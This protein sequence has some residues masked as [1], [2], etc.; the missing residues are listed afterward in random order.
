MKIFALE[1]IIR[2][3]Y[4]LLKAAAREP[5]RPRPEKKPELPRIDREKSWRLYRATAHE[6]LRDLLPVVR[7]D[8][9]A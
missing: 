4:D 5:L 1:R 8:Q 9:P 3:H 2:E 6:S 7:P